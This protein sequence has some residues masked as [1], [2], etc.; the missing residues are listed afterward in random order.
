MGPLARNRASKTGKANGFLSLL[1]F[2]KIEHIGRN[3]P[4]ETINHPLKTMSLYGL[5]VSL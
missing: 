2:F 4:H 5:T 3:R 1:Q